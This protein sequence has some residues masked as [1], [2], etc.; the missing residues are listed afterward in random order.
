MNLCHGG[1]EER[2]EFESLTHFVVAGEGVETVPQ[3]LLLFQVLGGGEKL[4]TPHLD[5]TTLQE[6]TLSHGAA[7]A[8]VSG[9]LR[10][11]FLIL[12]RDII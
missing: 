7:P 10:Q 6:L 11:S 5:P 1:G 8:T 12:S 4:L 2:D 3:C 9:D